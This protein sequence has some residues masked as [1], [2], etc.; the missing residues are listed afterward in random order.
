MGAFVCFHVLCRKYN[1][2]TKRILK[3]AARAGG[4][5]VPRVRFLLSGEEAWEDICLFLCLFV[6]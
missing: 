3:P 5:T 4:R 2:K 6:C 1:D